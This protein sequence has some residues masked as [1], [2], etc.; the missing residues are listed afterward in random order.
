MDHLKSRAQ[1]KRSLILFDSCVYQ[2]TVT[3]VRGTVHTTVTV[4]HNHALWGIVWD[5]KGLLGFFF[6]KKKK[7]GSWSDIISF[8]EEYE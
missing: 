8:Y 4:N 3:A 1:I 5:H 2:I 7:F 6:L